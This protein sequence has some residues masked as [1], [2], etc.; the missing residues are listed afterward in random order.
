MHEERTEKDDAAGADFERDEAALIELIRI[1]F[2]RTEAFDRAHRS[3]AFLV[4]AGRGFETTVLARRV[5]EEHHR[6]RHAIGHRVLV[7]PVRKVL[8]QDVFAAGARALHVE[9]FGEEH[10]VVLADDG[11]AWIDEARIRR[12]RGQ[13]G[14]QMRERLQ[15]LQHVGKVRLPLHVHREFL[16]PLEHIRTD[17]VLLS[18]RQRDDARGERLAIVR[19]RAAFARIEDAF[20]HDKTVAVERLALAGVEQVT[21]GA[22]RLVECSYVSPGRFRV[23]PASLA[24]KIRSVRPPRAPLCDR[25]AVG[26]S[27]SC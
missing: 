5:V 23:M 8:V 25:R 14:T 7:A 17:H 20:A 2:E 12:P 4:A 9:F 24:W 15:P 1:H 26:R 3:Y 22:T 10:D 16:L 18:V 6:G 11:F 21:V 19:D 27:T 13:L